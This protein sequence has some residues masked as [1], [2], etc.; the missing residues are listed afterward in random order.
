MSSRGQVPVRRAPW[1]WPER[2]LPAN[3]LHY[4]RIPLPNP[5][6]RLKIASPAGRR[7]SPHFKVAFGLQKPHAAFYL[8]LPHAVQQNCSAINEMKEK[9]Q[10]I[11]IR[12]PEYELTAPLWRVA[13]HQGHL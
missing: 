2:P 9:Q 8:Q 1:T 5:R 6:A 3:P 7:R 13:T 11:K 12:L 10:I 4:R